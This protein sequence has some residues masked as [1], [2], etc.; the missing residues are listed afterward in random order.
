VE[1]L[2]SVHADTQTIMGHSIFYET[3][4]NAKWDLVVRF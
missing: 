1:W 2:D 3:K 4:L